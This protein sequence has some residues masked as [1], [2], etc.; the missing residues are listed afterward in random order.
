VAASGIDGAEESAN[1]FDS[2]AAPLPQ[3]YLIAH[4]ASE[5][6]LE[7]LC[8]MTARLASDTPLPWR[9]ILLAPPPGTIPARYRN[10]VK[11][12]GTPVERRALLANATCYLHVSED[13]KIS[14]LMLQAWLHECPALVY[15]G[16]TIATAHVRLAQAG[17]CFDTYEEFRHAAMGLAREPKLGRDLGENG[18]RYVRRYFRWNTALEK[19]MRFLRHIE[20]RLKEVAA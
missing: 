3:P 15:S 12:S 16:S 10:I 2:L 1:A 18:R 6:A 14:P 5:Q 19:Q 13:E 17:L 4:V 9:L 8:E 7:R 20:Q 11:H